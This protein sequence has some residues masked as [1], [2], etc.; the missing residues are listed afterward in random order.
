MQSGIVDTAII[1]WHYWVFL[2]Q[3]RLI[4]FLGKKLPTP[5]K[6]PK[7]SLCKTTEMNCV[8]VFAELGLGRGCGGIFHLCP[9]MM[10]VE[11]RPT[12]NLGFLV[13]LL[14]WV[15]GRRNSALISLH[16]L[17]CFLDSGWRWTSQAKSW[18][19]GNAHTCCGEQSQPWLFSPHLPAAELMPFTVYI[20]F[21]ICTHNH[22]IKKIIHSF[23]NYINSNTHICRSMLHLPV[24]VE[25][26]KVIAQ[27][28]ETLHLCV[29]CPR[30]LYV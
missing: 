20:Y 13:R 23:I 15:G 12:D 11:S 4:C 21:F 27:L 18:V 9:G 30:S 29:A 2:H 26:N 5:V 24:P 28:P 22:K 8:S 7:L 19:Y 6:T 10:N 17:A 1:W 16:A 25:L 3:A 14:S